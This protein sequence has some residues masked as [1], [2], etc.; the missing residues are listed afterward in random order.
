MVR[1]S[2]SHTRE[3]VLIIG[4]V[5]FAAFMCRLD[6]SIVNIAMPAIGRFFN[7]GTSAISWV[8]LAYL[9]LIAALLLP[10]GKLGDTLGLKRVFLLGYAL[11]TAG[12]LLCGLSPGLVSL[13]VSR[14]V[15]G[16]GAA[17]LVATGYAI[18]PRFM[19]PDMTGWAFGMVATAGALGVTCGAPMGGVITGFLSW[20]WI[21]LIN[22]PVGIVAIVVAGRCLPSEVVAA[23]PGGLRRYDIPGSIL[24]IGCLLAG[25]LALNLGQELGWTSAPILTAMGAAAVLLPAFVLW[26]RVCLEP[27]FDLGLLRD[28]SFA[29][30]L[31]ASGLAF[32]AYAGNN[33]MLPFYLE[34]GKGLG[35][36]WAGPLLMVTSVVM[37]V[38]GPI[39]GRLSDRLSPRYLTVSGMLL[40]TLAVGAFAYAFRT[41]GLWVSVVFLVLVG[42]SFGM[43][44]SP[45]NSQVMSL[46]AAERQGAASG[47]FS[48]VN[49]VS[50]ALGIC[51]METI[52][53]QAMPTSHTSEHL[54]RAALDFPRGSLAAGYRAAL[55]SAAALCALAC[56]LSAFV[57]ARRRAGA[58]PVVAME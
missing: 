51:L 55:L 16:M 30:G 27:V 19:P 41:P 33:F 57:K 21:F 23:R 36:Q 13:I 39:A 9:L 50:N 56:L 35:T 54:K 40:A 18:V 29:A 31:L 17:L 15:Q 42:L 11:F 52:F 4:S 49:N 34:L 44:L 20:R 32:A 1:G 58:G 24:G 12:S 37:M 10:A 46:P 22:V 25:L 6:G 53:S 47:L 3:Q 45:N 28:R 2:Q 14:C 38:V 26:E 5:A 48:T 8:V 7:A 43:F